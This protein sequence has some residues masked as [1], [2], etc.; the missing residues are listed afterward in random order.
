MRILVIED[1]RKAARL[2]AQGL[3]EEGFDV[4]VAHSGEVGEEMVS[5]KE[6]A[7][8][9]LDWLLP[10]KDGIAVCRGLRKRNIATPILM[11]TARDSHGDRLIALNAGAG[12]YLVKP[13]AFLE[14]IARIHSLLSRSDPVHRPPR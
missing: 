11:L 2:L 8:I 5:S 3:R 1:D 4:D 6:Y 7:L 14:L 13:F 12:D 9:V 10:G